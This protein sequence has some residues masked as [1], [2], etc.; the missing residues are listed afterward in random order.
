[1]SLE[2]LDR[3][4]QHSVVTEQTFVWQNGMPEWKRLEA[5][6]AEHPDAEEAPEAPEER[7]SVLM[8]DRSVSSLGL[9]QIADLYRLGIIGSDTLLWQPGMS[10]WEKLG[11]LSDLDDCELETDPFASRPPQRDLPTARV[12]ASPRTLEPDLPTV[13]QAPIPATSIGLS[14]PPVALSISPPEDFPKRGSAVGRFFLR[15]GIAAA[16][17]FVLTRNDVF[18][19]AATLTR[20]DT[21]Y[22]SSERAALGGP[23]FGTPRAVQMLLAEAGG[24]LEPVRMPVFVTDLSTPAAASKAATKPPAEATR[25]PTPSGSVTSSPTS[26]GGAIQTPT[27]AQGPSAAVAPVAQKASSTALGGSVAAALLGQSKP[28]KVTQP[29]APARKA[30]RAKSSRS[31]SGTATGSTNY[32]DPLNGSL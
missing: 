22:L 8:D 10:G 25:T 21:R 30:V 16:F 31:K 27:A 7:F 15:A 1:M 4:F 20:Q 23:S 26:A 6:L 17:L 13:R 28:A 14:A 29:P 11:D 32:Y 24:P 3:Y 18:Y 9:D 19:S 5:V 2:Q 12:Q